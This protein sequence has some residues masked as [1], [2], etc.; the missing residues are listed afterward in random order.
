LKGSAGNLSAQRVVHLALRLEMMGRQEEL[1]GA[2][3][4]CEELE[5]EI[6]EVEPLLESLVTK[7]AA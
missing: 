2:A 4:L 5:C 7:E 3:E 1:A 6:V